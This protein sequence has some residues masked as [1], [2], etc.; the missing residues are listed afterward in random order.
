VFGPLV[1]ECVGLPARVT[2]DHEVRPRIGAEIDAA[3]NRAADRC[4]RKAA[5]MG[6][7]GDDPETAD[8]D[9]AGSMGRGE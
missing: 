8:E 5:L 9:D 6:E 4:Q 2:R 3:F 1:A 7:A